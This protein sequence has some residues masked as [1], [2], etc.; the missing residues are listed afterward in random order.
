[1]SDFLLEIGAENIPASYIDPAMKQLGADLEALLRDERLVHEGVTT[2][3]TPRRLVAMVS[4]M[5]ERQDASEELVT[6]PPVARAF[7]QEGNATKAAE[8]FARSQ[9][10]A[11]EKLQ[12]VTT[13]KGEY[14]GV[15]RRLPRR[16]AGAILRERLPV[17]LAGIRFPKSL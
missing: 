15:Q 12:R 10:I 14:L 7:D 5:S 3:A 11:V 17:L 9:G 16:S 8:G 4:A 6:G 1:M 2:A 13:D